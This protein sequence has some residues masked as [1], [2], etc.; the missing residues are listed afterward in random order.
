MAELKINGLKTK[1]VKITVFLLLAFL[2]GKQAKAH[3]F[4]DSKVEIYIQQNSLFLQFKTPLEILNLASKLQVDTLLDAKE[5]DSIKSYFLKHISAFDQLQSKWDLSF[6]KVFIQKTD[7]L[8]FGKYQEIVVEMYLTPSKKES[9]KSFSFFCDAITHQIVNQSTFL[10][11]KQ[12]IENGIFESNAR[13]VGIINVDFRTNKIL[14]VK[15]E[16]GKGGKYNGFKNMVVLGMQH[17]REGTDHLLFLLV[18]LLP[19]LLIVD[20]KQWCAFAGT[21]Q[22]LIKLINIIT[23]FT[24]GH[25]I[26][27]LFGA[28]GWASLPTQPVEIVIAISILVSAIHAIKPIFYGKEIFIAGGFGLIHGLAFASVLANL[29]LDTLGLVI[30]ILGF[31]L[32]IEFMQLLVVVL[33]IPCLILLAKTAYYKYVR[34]IGAVFAV[35]ASIIWILERASII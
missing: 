10:I 23:S 7:Y 21:K 3:S 30:S 28:L 6:G 29:H 19:A 17:I 26:T 14:P 16:L 20:Q 31:N 2:M 9:L 5:V 32:G 27:L 35:I 12:D 33:V 22:S 4:P 8:S 1:L 18:L 34:L 25:S 11:I 15:I 24:I 13:E